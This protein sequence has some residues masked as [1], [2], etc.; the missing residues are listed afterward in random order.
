MSKKLQ[1]VCIVP[2][3]EN[4]KRVKGKNFKKLGKL[5]L[6][7]HLFKKLL[8]TNFDEIYIDSDST[9]VEKSSKKYGF[10]FIKRLKKL[11]KDNANGNDLLNYHSSIISADLF[12]QLFVTSPFLKIDTI[13]QCIKKLKNSKH[14]DS[15]LTAT[16]IY[17][18]FWFKNTA[19][20]YNPKV[21][22]R[23]QNAKPIIR[24]TTALYGIKKE[25]LKKIKCRIGNKPIFHYVDFIESLD[26][27]E[28]IDFKIVNSL[29]T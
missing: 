17:S 10:K 15:I 29:I 24:E 20:N 28:S 6:F 23:S 25:A 3:K 26:I 18:W 22:P 12:F 14:H 2:I 4:S 8:K 11:S 21:L 16:K 7:E 1:I 19:V 9:V 5:P 27:D 13:N